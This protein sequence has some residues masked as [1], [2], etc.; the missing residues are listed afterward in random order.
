MVTPIHVRQISSTLCGLA[1]AVG[2]QAQLAANV[3]LASENNF[4]GNSLSDNNPV[5]AFSLNADSDS[6]W[7]AGAVATWARFDRYRYARSSP[8]WLADVG[9]ARDTGLGWSWEVGATGSWFTNTSSYNYHEAFAGIT[10]NRWNVRFFYSPAY[11]GQRFKSVYGE[12]NYARPL[13]DNL[14]L[15]AHL[16]WQR[17]NL[18][19]AD[20]S[21]STLDTRLGLGI[22]VGRVGIQASWVATNRESYLYPVDSGSYHNRFVLR[23]D[24]A[25]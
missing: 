11:Y 10:V 14:H 15:L 2:A 22:Q 25:L 5:A 6:G 16:G 24:Y 1:F 21:T 18:D 4:R 19:G 8:Q 7:F 3:S 12:L 13:T 20:A 9:Y 23:L 17:A